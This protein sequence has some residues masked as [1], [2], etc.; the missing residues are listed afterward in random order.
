MFNICNSRSLPKEYSLKLFPLL[1]TI[2]KSPQ[3]HLKENDF[4]IPLSMFL[5]NV[6]PEAMAFD[7][8][9][10]HFKNTYQGPHSKPNESESLLVGG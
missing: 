2:A 10:E 3:A 6:M 1:F 7:F 5:K 9:L 4:L 8:K